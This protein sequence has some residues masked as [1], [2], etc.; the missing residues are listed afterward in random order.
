MILL[1]ALRGALHALAKNSEV[2]SQRKMSM[3]SRV[4]Q[5]TSPMVRKLRDFERAVGLAM[6]QRQHMQALVKNEESNSNSDC[7]CTAPE[8]WARFP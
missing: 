5:N 4:L 1:F 3:A 6:L 8:A 2:T 7:E